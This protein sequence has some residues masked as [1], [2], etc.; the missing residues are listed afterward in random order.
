[1]VTPMGLQAFYHAI[2]SREREAT[3]R[4]MYSY[5]PR[6]EDVCEV[7]EEV[8]VADAVDGRV[9]GYAEEEDVC[10]EAGAVQCR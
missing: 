1:M 5:K 8:G 9:D 3:R 7:V 6:A 10:E 4:K 2:K